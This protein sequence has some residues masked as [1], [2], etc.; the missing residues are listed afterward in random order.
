MVIV[1]IS[2]CA[3]ILIAVTGLFAW[4][5]ADHRREDQEMI[6]LLRTQPENPSVFDPDSVSELPEPAQRFFKFSIAPGTPLYTVARIQMAGQFSMGTKIN[7]KY[8]N[9][10][11]TQ[12]L[13]SPTGFIWV[14]SSGS[15]LTKI[16][17]SDSQN[18]TRFWIGSILPVARLGRTIDHKRSAFGRYSAESVFWTP[19]AILPGSGIQWDEV[20][21]DTAS[22]TINHD[23]LSQR[24]YVQVDANGAPTKVFFSRWTD[25]N[26][27]KEYQLQPFGG[28]LSQFRDIGGFR[29]PTHVEAGNFFD[30]DD[31]FPFF[32][33]DVSK[34]NF[35]NL[36][37][38]DN[39][40]TE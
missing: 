12:V 11:A 37:D 33:V 40:K 16:S 18:W 1:L 9:I 21:N 22:V 31:Y 4:R 29:L 13:A 28:Y 5:K 14:M 26:P 17:G 7:P 27:D 25:A 23:G 15:G 36:H 24:V 39:P 30:T 38:T 35:P 3:L 6:R 20:D 8:I 34:I 19:A 10:Q 32:I 2:L